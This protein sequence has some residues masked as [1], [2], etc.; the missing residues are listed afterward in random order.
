MILP[1]KSHKIKNNSDINTADIINALSEK[2]EKENISYI[3]LIIVIT[4]VNF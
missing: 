4:K 1:K 3:L 2:Y